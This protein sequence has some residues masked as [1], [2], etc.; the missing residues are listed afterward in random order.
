MATTSTYASRAMARPPQPAVHF[1]RIVL[2]VA[3]LLI[4]IGATAVVGLWW[5]DTTSVVGLAGW[6]TNAGRVTG[7]LAGYACAVLLALMS[8]F[9]LLERGVGSDRLARWHALGGR[10]T[11]S[12]TLAHTLLIILGSAASAHIS[13]VS[14]TTT[15][16]LTYPDMLTATAGFLLLVAAGIVS[17]RAARRRLRYETWHYLH[18]TTYL[19]IF[20]AF[21]HP[22][23]NGADFV[24]HRPVQLAWYAIYIGVAA[25]LVWYRFLT[26]VRRALR[27]RLTVAE[28]RP[29]APGVVSVFMTGRHLDELGAEPG[30]FFRW[31]FLAPG[32]WWTANPYSLSAPPNRNF[33]RITVK[34][35]GGHSE[36]LARIRPG[37]RVWAEGPY[38]AFTAA[39]RTARRVLLLGG[40]VGI[41]PLRALFETLPGEVTVVYRARRPEDL[42]LWQELDAI[43]A[44]RGAT[45]HYVVDEPV[46]YSSPLTA[47]GLVSLVSDIAKRDVYLCGPPG[48][49]AAAIPALRRAGV[50]RRRIH[51]ESFAF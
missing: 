27:H 22:L 46:E 20:L 2:I 1:P 37:T 45:V 44:D 42:A 4:Y 12:L 34:A 8:R 9:P 47:A 50:P 32:M 36:A 28:V 23:S 33:L 26:P 24:L 41:T 13:V 5:V 39:R 43:A 40:G 6:L 10:Y 25:L 29:E 15:L 3:Q 17:A 35:V 18:F 14:Q 19:A 48:M 11:I 16:V 30:Q 7:L 38:G 21:S 51:H 31:R 49:T